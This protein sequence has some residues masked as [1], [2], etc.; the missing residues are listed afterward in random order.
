MTTGLAVIGAWTIVCALAAWFWPPK[1][2]H[3]TEAEA[4]PDL[5]IQRRKRLRSVVDCACDACEAN[6][7]KLWNRDI[8]LKE[9]H[10]T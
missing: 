4:F 5:E 10:D 2:R 6:R 7:T 8:D 9:H 3:M 1:V